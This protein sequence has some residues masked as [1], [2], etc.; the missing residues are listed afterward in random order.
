MAAIWPF[1]PAAAAL[2]PEFDGTPRRIPVCARIARDAIA[3]WR[4]APEKLIAS[5]DILRLPSAQNA[6]QERLSASEGNAFRIAQRAALTMDPQDAEPSSAIVAVLALKHLAAPRQALSLATLH[7]HLRGRAPTPL[8]GAEHAELARIVADLATRSHATIFYSASERSAR[9]NPEAAAAPQIA[10]F[11]RALPLLRYFRADLAEVALPSELAAALERA[12]EAMA[13]VLEEAERSRKILREA[14]H[15][16]GTTLAPER[17]RTLA[18]VIEIARRGPEGVPAGTIAEGAERSLREYATIAAIAAAVPRLRAMREYLCDLGL[19]EPRDDPGQSDAIAR[20][21]SEC[22]LLI[23]DIGGAL[24]ARSSAALDA[25][26]SWQKDME[27]AV[28][29]ATDA[30]QYV[31]ALERLNTIGA[32]GAPLA[33]ELRRELTEATPQLRSCD[34]ETALA[35][36]V[37]PR[38]PRCHFVLGTVAPIEALAAIVDRARRALDEKLRLL[39]QSAVIRLIRDH[40]RGRRLEGFL[41][42]TQ[43][44]Q[45]DAIIKVLDDELTEYLASLLEENR[46]APPTAQRSDEPAVAEASASKVRSKPPRSRATVSPLLPAGGRAKTR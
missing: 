32:L 42:I 37:T 18:D 27:Q 17:E 23:V 1:Q 20:L 7:E 26:E 15:D 40:D 16:F 24:H 38:C 46:A 43:A 10:A 30:R 33:V 6:L 44:A 19:I 25:L 39:S 14:A 36:E 45:A 3:A 34:P 21:E 4:E 2:L 28:N 29:L 8:S 9:F 13:F 5:A 31:A 35:P 22:K 12:R 41:K 11:N